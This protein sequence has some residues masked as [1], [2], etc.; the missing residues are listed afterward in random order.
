[1]QSAMS[2]QFQVSSCPCYNAVDCRYDKLIL[3][4]IF[5]GTKE[6]VLLI[7]FPNEKTTTHNKNTLQ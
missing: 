2:I 6:G 3:M 7:F 4:I 1:M 5:G